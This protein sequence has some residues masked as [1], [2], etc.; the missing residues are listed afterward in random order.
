MIFH[1]DEDSGL[2]DV[3]LALSF[4]QVTQ[5][6]HGY[7]RSL[8]ISPMLVI[9]TPAQG[10]LTCTKIISSLEHWG[11]RSIQGYRGSSSLHHWPKPK[12]SLMSKPLEP[13]EQNSSIQ[14]STFLDIVRR[15]TQDRNRIITGCPPGPVFQYCSGKKSLSFNVIRSC[16][17]SPL[18]FSLLAQLSVA[19][20]TI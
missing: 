3:V 15:P 7:W 6:A 11:S 9:L 19:T 4:I 13:L 20:N 14:Y 16:S 12:A 10:S 18:L 8:N 2:S 1:Y 17:T 5:N